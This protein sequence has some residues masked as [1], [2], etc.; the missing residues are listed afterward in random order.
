MN[1]LKGIYWVVHS[2]IRLKYL[3]EMLDAAKVLFKLH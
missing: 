3:C 2:T 1:L